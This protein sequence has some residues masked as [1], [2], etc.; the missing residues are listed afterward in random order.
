MVLLIIYSKP[1]KC[2][3]YFAVKSMLELCSSKWLKNKKVVINNNNSSFQNSL[4]DAF[5][6]YNIKTD[7]ERI[8]KVSLF[9]RQYNWKGMEFLSHHEYRKQFE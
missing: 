7:P 3:Y 5:N 6:C 1:K 4:N 2:Y 9:I 8:S